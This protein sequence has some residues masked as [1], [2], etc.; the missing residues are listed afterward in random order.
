MEPLQ[1]V[2]EKVCVLN[3]ENID[4]D[5][6]IP[7]EYL[8]SIER[9]GFDKGLFAGWRYLKDGSDNPE[10]ELNTKENQNSG[11]LIV[12]NNFGCGSSR[13]H[14]VWALQQYGIKAIIAPKKVSQD[15]TLYAFADIF[16]NN[17]FKNGLLP[18]EMCENDVDDLKLVAFNNP[19]QEMTIQLE[20]QKIYFVDVSKDFEIDPVRKER[21]LKGLDDIALTLAFEEEL[22]KYESENQKV[23]W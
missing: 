19:D 5:Q 8:K 4:T 22:Q 10:F 7:K 2:K 16:K 21:I 20:E 23:I 18:I 14:A 17:A 12:G 11:V 15:K 13:E 6:I 3:R 9:V 1:C